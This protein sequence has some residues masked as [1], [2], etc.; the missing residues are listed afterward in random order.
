M[1]QMPMWSVSELVE[2]IDMHRGDILSFAGWCGKFEVGG[3]TTWTLPS[4]ASCADLSIRTKR[5]VTEETKNKTGISN[6]H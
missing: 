2:I 3:G 5:R 6:A 1:E 4:I